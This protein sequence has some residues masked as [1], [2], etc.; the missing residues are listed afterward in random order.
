MFGILFKHPTQI[1]SMKNILIISFFFLVFSCKHEPEIIIS[2]EKCIEN[3]LQPIINTDSINFLPCISS[4]AII[5]EQD[6]FWEG[7]FNPKD[8]NQIVYLRLEI[9]ISPHSFQLWVYDFC[10]NSHKMLATD[11]WGRFSWSAKNWIL[12]IGMDNTLRK[13]KP[14][15]D[16]LTILTGGGINSSAVWNPSGDKIIYRHQVNSTPM[17]IIMDEFGLALDT[18]E[19][20]YSASA[21]SWK[22]ENTIFFQA[23]LLPPPNRRYGLWS[24][25]METETIDNIE[26]LDEHFQDGILKN[27]IYAKHSNRLFWAGQKI[28]GYTDLLTGSRTVLAYS[29]RNRWYWRFNLSNDEKTI[30]VGRVDMSPIEPCK[31]LYEENLFLID[32]ETGEESKVILPQ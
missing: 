32:V 6:G 2:E 11:T 13:I 3:Y 18:I 27:T 19:A 1:I 22:D 26:Y 10:D 9:D 30:L 28:V 31:D 20:I 24:Y 8:E 16:S 7:I 17:A 12:F 21:F 4:P 15:G 25:N 29:T 23:G 14:N 5:Y